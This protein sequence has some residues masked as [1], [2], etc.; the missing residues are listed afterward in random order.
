M[1]TA[2]ASSDRRDAGRESLDLNG[3]KI[4]DVRGVIADLTDRAVAPTAGPTVN[5]G[6]GVH[7]ADADSRDTRRQPLDLHGNM[8][9]Y[10][11]VIAKLAVIVTAP[12][13]CPAIN[14]CTAVGI[15]A[16]ADGRDTRRQAVNLNGDMTFRRRAIAERTLHVPTPALRSPVDHGT[17][18]KF[19]AANGR[20][21]RRQSLDLNWDWA[22]SGGVVAEL[23]VFIVTPA[24]H[25]SVDDSAGV[26]I[27]GRDRRDDCT[28]SVG[29]PSSC[30]VASSPL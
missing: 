6:A 26:V 19:A 5:H 1:S 13:V 20:C 18:V 10:R 4:E 14:Q 16:G 23:A 2:N 22:L 15:A 8:A 17:G 29:R 21:A 9:F 28:T 11:G 7:A 12:A 27:A 24:L 25:S 3:D 30:R